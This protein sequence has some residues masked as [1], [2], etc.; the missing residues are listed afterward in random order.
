MAKAIGAGQVSGGRLQAYH[1]QR[2][3]YKR[4][5][6]LWLQAL[7]EPETFWAAA[8]SASSEP[9]LTDAKACVATV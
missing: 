5:S 4:V 6:S 9:V 2:Y 1:A 3:G 7:L 8:N